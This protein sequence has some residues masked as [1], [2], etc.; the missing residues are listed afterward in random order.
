[1]LQT[2]VMLDDA[3]LAHDTGPHHPE[4]ADRL[5]AIGKVVETLPADRIRQVGSR[6]ASAEELGR[7]HSPEHVARVAATAK[8][9]R[10]A[11]D[12]DTPT[13]S[14][15]YEAA[16]RAAG[17]TLEVVDAVIAG[18]ATNGFA[19]VRPPG[20]HA[21]PDRAMGFCLF[22]NVALA[23]AHLRAKHGLERV[24]IVDW[25]VHHGNG[26][27][28]AFYEDPN[29]LFVSSHQFPFYPGTGSAFEVGRGAG[30]GFTLNV[31]LP[32]GCGDSE[33]V[34]AYL[35]LVEPVAREFH[36]EFVLVSAGFDAH[37]RDPLA[38]MEVTEEGFRR[39]ARIVARVAR[40]LCGNR[41]VAVLE[42]GYDLHGL[43]TSVGAVIDELGGERLGELVTPAG[44]AERRA[45]IAK[46]LEVAKHFWR[47]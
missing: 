42:G 4:R 33:Y 29:V 10:F 25:D 18:R 1:M 24:M 20:H 8:L 16:L 37:A 14:G 13:S 46:S 40:D 43:A 32:G 5:R 45:P 22:N 7:V 28:D 36:P 30:E 26:T 31:P 17:G 47:I 41:L 39:L 3:F 9:S 34:E 19:L 2:A 12:A 15:S 44:D 11:F 38:E 6:R 35:E 21:V 27:Q 23:A